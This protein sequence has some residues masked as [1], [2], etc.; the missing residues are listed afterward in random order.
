M[1]HTLLPISHNNIKCLY[2]SEEN[3]LWIGTS[4]KGIN[5]FDI[6]QQKIQTLRHEKDNPNSI[7]SDWVYSIV[8]DHKGSIWIGTYGHGLDRLNQQTGK[9]THYNKNDD[10]LGISSNSIRYMLV[11]SKDQL[12]IG[13]SKGLCRYIDTSNTFDRF[14]AYEHDTTT[15]LSDDIYCIYE[16]MKGRIWVGTYGGGLNML[17]DDYQTFTR[18]TVEDGLPGHIVYGIL[19]DNSGF[20]WISTN[21]GLTRFDPAKSLFRNFDSDDGL[22]GD[23]YNYNSFLKTSQG[24]LFFGGKN[25]LISFNPNQITI[26]SHIPNVVFTGLKLFNEPVDIN[27]DSG[28]LKKQLNETSAIVLKHYQDIITF[29]FSSL[30]YINPL[31]NRYAYRLR[32]L[33]ESWTETQLP[34]ATFMNLHSGNYTLEVKASNNDGLWNEDPIVLG[35]HVLPP[36]WKTIWAYL[37]YFT[38]LSGIIYWIFRFQKSR[39]NLKHQFDLNQL[40]MDRQTELHQLKLKYFT[41]ISH[42]I[43]TPLTLLITPLENLLK[44]YK[45]DQNLYNQLIGLRNNADRLLRLVNQL[46]DFR[47]QET[48]KLELKQAEGNIIKFIAEI[49]LAFQEE[50]K[51]RNVT[52]SFNPHQES[53]VIWYDRNELEKVIFNLLSN[54]FKF[55]DEG[56]T[57]SIDTERTEIDVLGKSTE[58]IKIKITNSGKGIPEDKLPMIFDRFYQV[59]K[60]GLTEYGSGI[61]LALSK[62]IVELHKGT[63]SV[64]SRSKDENQD[65][66]ASFT[67]ILPHGNNHITEK[68]R[69]P[70]FKNSESIEVYNF[71]NEKEDRIETVQTDFHEANILVVEDNSEIRA[72]ICQA[73]EPFYTVTEAENGEIAWEIASETIPDLVISDVL[74]P[75]MDGLELCQKIKS[76]YR[77]NH[78][79]VILLTARTAL[80]HKVSGL[81]TGADEYIVKPFNMQ[82]LMLRI[83]NLIQ[84]RKRLQEKYSTVLNFLPEQISEESSPDEVFLKHTAEIIELQLMNSQFSVIKLA[85]EIGMSQS[86]LYRKIKAI[87]NLSPNEFI[88]KIRLNKAAQILL[89][90]EAKVAEVGYRV[91]FNDPKYFSQTFKRQFDLTPSEFKRKQQ[92]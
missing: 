35:I 80:I 62:G 74:M 55:T 16:D 78:I 15:L 68:N 25:G 45:E 87:T 32:G 64:E 8:D 52:L 11:D 89:S 79:P 31:K 71:L 65:G 92:N 83:Q 3:K 91:G 69:L 75:V 81:Q 5:I 61:G 7:I 10:S 77:T 90:E 57:I 37:L 46:M 12:W 58:A 21:N 4:G 26:N 54:A 86:V 39:T 67:V 49:S 2:L 34:E 88:R 14:F 59:E 19:E 38:I 56:G 47:K 29:K 36:P 1:D 33:S 23:E 41:N 48:G 51:R 18:Y 24:E 42:E 53:V 27:D 84:L 43:R 13:T 22:P 9:I 30:N 85:E 20:L 66:Y 73:L 60:Q 70:Y 72:L 50:A 6:H 76:D 17:N 44:S 82:I 63:I 28:L 40:Q